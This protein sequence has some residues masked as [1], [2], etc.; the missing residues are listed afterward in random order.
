[1]FAM[2]FIGGTSSIVL[3]LLLYNIIFGFS[4][5]KDSGS[6]TAKPSMK[7][8]KLLP[9]VRLPKFKVQVS[10]HLNRR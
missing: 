4:R 9:Q 10:V 6:P 8:I 5:N 1:M 3:G 2:I 7:L